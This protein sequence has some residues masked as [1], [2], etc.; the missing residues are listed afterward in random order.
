MKPISPATPS[1][2]AS[3]DAQQPAAPQRRGP[4]PLSP[5]QLRQVGGGSPKGGWSGIEPMSSPKGGWA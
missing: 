3:T 5:E 4:V 1:V 2:P